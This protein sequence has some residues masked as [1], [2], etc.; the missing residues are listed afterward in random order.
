MTNLYISCRQMIASNDYDDVLTN[1]FDRYVYSI[2]SAIINKSLGI[3]NTVHRSLQ[4]F[5]FIELTS[6]L[7]ADSLSH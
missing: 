1:L 6:T 4:W 7:H 3:E 2:M 5:G